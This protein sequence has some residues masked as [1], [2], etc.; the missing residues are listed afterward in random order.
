MAVQCFRM[1][2]G[3]RPIRQ[4][5][6]AAPEQSHLLAFPR[7]YY[8]D[9]MDDGLLRILLESLESPRY[10]HQAHLVRSRLMR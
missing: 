7:Q 2:H 4:C 6:K 1:C 5:G 3:Q 9:E 8:D 10:E